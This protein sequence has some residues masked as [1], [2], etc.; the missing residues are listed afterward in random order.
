[1]YNLELIQRFWDFN[2]SNRVG[3]TAV[4]V[5]LYLVKLSG[6]NNR[7][8]FRVSDLKISSEL[9]LTRATISKTR[10]KL[11]KFGLIAFETTN[12][13]P[14]Y[15]RL[16]INYPI[17]CYLED[18]PDYFPDEPNNGQLLS[19]RSTS[20]EF[21]VDENEEIKTLQQPFVEMPVQVLAQSSNPSFEA[22]LAFA[23]HLDGYDSTLDDAIKGKYILWSENNWKT[24]SDR[25]I[26]NWRSTLKSMM[27]FFKKSIEDEMSWHSIPDI[28]HL[29]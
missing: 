13:I 26:T 6:E 1:M 5:Y 19:S 15:Y 12:G 7:Y 9:G 24:V 17:R 4:A 10:N 14:C 3:S 11:K 28:K 25:P 8:D 21:C 29:K 23:Q 20:S 2:H 22:F 27:P 18:A 16:I